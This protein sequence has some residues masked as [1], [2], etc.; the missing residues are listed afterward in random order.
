MSKKNGHIAKSQLVSITRIYQVRCQEFPIQPSIIVGYHEVVCRYDKALVL[1][2]CTVAQIQLS[3]SGK[4]VA[5]LQRQVADWI[6][7]RFHLSQ[8]KAHAYACEREEVQASMA[9]GRVRTN[10]TTKVRAQRARWIHDGHI[11]CAA[12]RAFMTNT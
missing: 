6:T 11:S 3:L 12:P 10:T 2:Q 7:L 8:S 1:A 4:P 9:T 5:D